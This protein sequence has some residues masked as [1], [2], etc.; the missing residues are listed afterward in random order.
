MNKL[1]RIVFNVTIAAGF[2]L[3]AHLAATVLIGGA[4]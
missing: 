4:A 1:S 2:L 3:V